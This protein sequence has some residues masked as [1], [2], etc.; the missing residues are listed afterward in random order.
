LIPPTRRRFG[1]TLGVSIAAPEC[2]KFAAT[3]SRPH[4]YPLLTVSLSNDEGVGRTKFCE[5]Q[6]PKTLSGGVEVT[7]PPRI[8]RH[9]PKSSR[10]RLKLARNRFPRPES[11]PA[12]LMQ[13]AV[14]LELHDFSILPKIRASDGASWGAH[15]SSPGLVISSCLN[16]GVP[17][18]PTKA[19]FVGRG[20]C[21]ARA[22]RPG[23][24]APRR[25]S[26]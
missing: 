17:V 21:C 24:G 15:G 6:R 25:K 5:G 14:T 26:R 16:S 20:A 12:D 4:D 7:L 19:A 22:A 18:K 13:S 11:R 2:D 10:S 1:H 23:F 8:T 9:C 3:S